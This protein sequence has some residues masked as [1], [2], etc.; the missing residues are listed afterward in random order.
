MKVFITGAAGFIGGS[1]AAGLA[2]A[3]HEVI[4]LVRKPEQVA[5]LAAIGVR[6]CSARWTTARC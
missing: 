3:G 4:G 5:E 2:R 6:A 1:I